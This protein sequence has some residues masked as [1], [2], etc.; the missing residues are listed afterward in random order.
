MQMR[1]LKRFF[2]IFIVTLILASCAKDTIVMEPPAPPPAPP[3][4]NESKISYS[5]AIQ[6]IF[7]EKCISCHGNGGAA[8]LLVDGKSYSAL[9]NTS[10][11]ID[12]VTPGNS[13]LHK[14][15]IAGDG[16]TMFDKGY[17]KKKDADSVYKWIRQGAKNN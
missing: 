3:S 17:C 4:P 6:P 16:T 9:M 7:T 15:M 2:T 1:K 8:P 14:E 12:T 5:G 13:I 10:G 11:M